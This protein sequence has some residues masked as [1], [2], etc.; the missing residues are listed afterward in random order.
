MIAVIKSLFSFDEE[1]PNRYTERLW[2]EVFKSEI[3][4]RK[5][6]IAPAVARR[7]ESYGEAPPDYK[8]MLR[9]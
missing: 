4:V 1:A 9:E 6:I 5:E 7:K 3:D 2:R 8:S